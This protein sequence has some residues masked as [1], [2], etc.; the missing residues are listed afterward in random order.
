V[1]RGKATGELS[2]DQQAD[3]L[4]LLKKASNGLTASEGAAA[5]FAKKP[6]KNDA[7]KTCQRFEA[8]VKQGRAHRIDGSNGGVGGNADLLLH[9]LPPEG[10]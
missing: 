9:V 2:I 7:E 1:A 6:D 3:L 10:T 8:L 5:F 4:D